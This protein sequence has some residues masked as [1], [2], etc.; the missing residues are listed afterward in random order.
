MQKYTKSDI[1]IPN[2]HS[3][4][5]W[6]WCLIIFIINIDNNI[7]NKIAISNVAN[8]QNLIKSVNAWFDHAI[9]ERSESENE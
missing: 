7:I 1:N 8:R 4:H 6:S 3:K 5:S 9:V 2:K